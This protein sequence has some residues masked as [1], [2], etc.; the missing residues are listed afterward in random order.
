MYARV[1]I[2][3]GLA[4][5][6]AASVSDHC[7][8]AG[9]R[10]VVIK[11]WRSLWKL[12][13]SLLKI[14]F[15]RLALLK[16]VEKYPDAKALFSAVGV[17]TPR[18]GAF[19][20]HSL[21]VMNGLDMIISLLPN[22][23]ALDEALDHLAHQHEVRKGVKKEHFAAMAGILNDALSVAVDS[24]DTMAWKSCFRGIFKKLAARQTA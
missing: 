5:M 13:S 11:Q 15:G 7:C 22:P 6:A 16:L 2:L 14:R 17:D 4:C 8:S 10:S 20:A 23:D 1:L 3:L 12:E 18:G 21:R 24:Y 9:D 19:S